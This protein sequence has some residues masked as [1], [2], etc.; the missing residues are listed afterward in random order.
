MS[1]AYNIRIRDTSRPFSLPFLLAALSVSA[2]FPL[3]F[4]VLPAVFAHVFLVLFRE[5]APEVYF[6]P[7]RL[8]EPLSLRSPPL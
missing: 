8:Q 2:F 5:S 1:G 4:I 3:L 6:L 7:S